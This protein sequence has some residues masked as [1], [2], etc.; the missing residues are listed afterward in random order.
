MS[1]PQD[2][3]LVQ[4]QEEEEEG[5]EDRSHHAAGLSPSPSS[6]RAS[7]AARSSRARKK[8]RR[9]IASDRDVGL[10]TLAYVYRSSR[11]GV[12]I[13]VLSFLLLA[14]QLAIAAI[15]AVNQSD[16]YIRSDLGWCPGGGGSNDGRYRASDSQRAL[17][18]FIG[19]LYV[20]KLGSKA[21]AEKPDRV[22]GLEAPL[23]KATHSPYQWFVCADRFMDVAFEPLVYVLNL[24]VVS[25]TTR[26]LDMVLNAV[27]LEFILMLDNEFKDYLLENFDVTD[28]MLDKVIEA[29]SRSPPRGF[30]CHQ[31]FIHLFTL[32]LLL[33]LGLC[34]AFTLVVTVWFIF[35]KL[36]FDIQHI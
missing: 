21:L 22:L 23:N 32:A 9:R 20:V 7:R 25:R 4:Q 13:L 26:E 16:E 30:D 14:S 24:F 36:S 33:V 34:L 19:L 11:Y 8:W 6:Q 31:A 29:E 35:C 12:P 10:A 2:A 17:A 5:E 15:L 1:D 28:E 3:E 27:A 18:F